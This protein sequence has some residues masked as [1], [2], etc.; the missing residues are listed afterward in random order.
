MRKVQSSDDVANLVRP[1]LRDLSREIFKILLLTTRNHII[2]EKTVFEGSLSESLVN[3][4]E[5]IKEALNEAAASIIFVN[6]HPS[7]NPTPSSEDKRI[8]IQLKNACD[9]IGIQVLDHK[10]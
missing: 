9:L 1:Y 4:R 8:T 10:L 7:G 6:N 2:C 3:P 5:I